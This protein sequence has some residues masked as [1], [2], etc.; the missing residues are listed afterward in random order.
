MKNYIFI[1]VALII[2]LA[3]LADS[4]CPDSLYVTQPNG[5]TLWTYL[6]G[7]E[8]YHWRTTIDGHVIMRD[9]N[10]YYRYVL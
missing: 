6:H 2:S 8:Y 7:N 5:D 10:N 4:A 1:I 9:T 3:A